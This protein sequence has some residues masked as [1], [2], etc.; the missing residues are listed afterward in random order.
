MFFESLSEFDSNSHL[1]VDVPSD[2]LQNYK[3][4]QKLFSYDH[5]YSSGLASHYKQLTS[6]WKIWNLPHLIFF[7]CK[8]QIDR[9]VTMDG[10][11]IGRNAVSDSSSFHTS[12]HCLWAQTSNTRLS[13]DPRAPKSKCGPVGLSLLQG[14]FFPCYSVSC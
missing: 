9:N 6:I 10:K 11:I 14:M 2:S 13:C 3:D 5:P 7:P 4:F 8:V 1:P 12:C